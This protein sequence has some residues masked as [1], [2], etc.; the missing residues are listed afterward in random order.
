MVLELAEV[1]RERHMLGARDVLVAEEQHLVLQQQRTDFGDEPGVARR[2]AQ[3]DVRKLGADRAGHWLD[4]DRAT[5]PS[6]GDGGCGGSCS[7]HVLSLQMMSVRRVADDA[8]A[9][10]VANCWPEVLHRVV[11]G[12]AVVPDRDAVPAKAEA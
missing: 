7:S 5:R 4:L 12:A 2:D 10:Q 3:V 8:G 11:L 6:P 9:L 1:P